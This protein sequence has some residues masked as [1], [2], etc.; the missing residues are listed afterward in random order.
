MLPFSNYKFYA[1]QNTHPRVRETWTHARIVRG[2]KESIDNKFTPI[3]KKK[4]GERQLF[5]S[6]RENNFRRSFSSVS[7]CITPRPSTGLLLVSVPAP[8]NQRLL[9][10]VGPRKKHR[11]V[12][13]ITRGRRGEVE[14]HEL[15]KIYRNEISKTSSQHLGRSRHYWPD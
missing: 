14:R 6:R 8:V 15:I 9:R 5:F 1:P 2:R 7:P 4:K 13:R 3:V 10:N 11:R 12:G